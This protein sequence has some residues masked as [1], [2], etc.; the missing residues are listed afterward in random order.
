MRDNLSME[1]IFDTIQDKNLEELKKDIDS[2][3]KDVKAITPPSSP[4]IHFH[5]ADLLFYLRLF[6]SVKKTIQDILSRSCLFEVQDNNTVKVTMSD[7][8][9]KGSVIIPFV[10]KSD[11][12]PNSMILDYDSIVKVVGFAGKH[13]YLVY[14]KGS[15]YVEFHGGQVHL[16][17]FNVDKDRITGRIG[18]SGD[19]FV[20][21]ESATLLRHVGM[22][23]EFLKLVQIPNM[24]FM[25]VKPN[26]IFLS[27][28]YTVLKIDSPLKTECCVGRN[29][30]SFLYAAAQ[31]AQGNG[32]GYLLEDNRLTIKAESVELS[33]PLISEHFPLAYEK[34]LEK[35]DYTSFYKMSFST[36]QLLLSVMT[37][38]Y[39]ASGLVTLKS[40]S[41]VLV[42]ETVSM[43]GKKSHVVLSKDAEGY[44]QDQEL[45][46]K[47]DGLL[48]VIRS[49]KGSEELRLTMAGNTFC[50]FNDE[51]KLA[52][53]GTDA[54]VKLDMHRTLDALSQ[55]SKK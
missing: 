36:L 52:V 33:L 9:F 44:V 24:L 20:D 55:E 41:S 30:L 39:R 3:E 15:F 54:S 10:N 43:D 53:F 29:D 51:A 37:K 35:F 12:F 34:Y 13:V 14:E 28:G 16:Y 26:G 42:L 8:I 4:Y 11:E 40:V 49:M 22:A 6:S 45:S 31:I 21:M 17:N 25:F 5:T 50:V 48:S 7:G 1:S 19:K 47:V 46:F 27:N 2:L 18:F 23:Q 38:M 32:L